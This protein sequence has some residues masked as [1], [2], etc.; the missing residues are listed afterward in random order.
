MRDMF[1]RRT[2]KEVYGPLQ[3][4]T[5][6]NILIRKLIEEYGYSDK[7][8]I[9]EV[10]AEDILET[11]DKYL[12]P[13]SRVKPG[14]MVW[15]AV[16]EEE[17]H[18]FGKKM[19]DAKMVPV[20]LTLVNDKDLKAYKEGEKPYKVR[21]KRV[22]RLLQEAK[23][24]GGVLAQTDLGVILGVSCS[25]IGHYIR[26]YQD[27]EEKV[28]PTRGVVHDMGSTTAHK[29]QI[30]ELYLKGYT[31][32]DIAR[33]TDHDPTSVDRYIRDFERVRLLYG[34]LNIHEIANA[35]QMS[36]TLVE[37]YIEIIKEHTEKP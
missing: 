12:P 13:L 8:K 28:L 35:A 27:V 10:L 2:A 5:L 18:G 23:A 16:S 14:Q 25:M 29:T 7:L 36:T 31:T 19:K 24:Q 32:P 33:I 11:I 26:T 34:R 3:E 9:A 30:I 21:V 22:S 17:K 6:K 1:G 4:K 20:V 15:L 37:Q